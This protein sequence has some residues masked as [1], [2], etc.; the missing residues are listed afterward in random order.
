MKDKLPIKEPL[1]TSFQE[2]E[3]VVPVAVTQAN[4]TR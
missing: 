1:I 4:S 3:L 2:N